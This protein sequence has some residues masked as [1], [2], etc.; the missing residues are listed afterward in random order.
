MRR[1][2]LAEVFR[3]DSTHGLSDIY[4]A[5][6]PTADINLDGF[7][8]QTDIPGLFL[9]SSGEADART[10]VELPFSSRIRELFARLH[11]EFDYV[12]IDTPPSIQFSDARILGQI[13]DGVILV[14]RSGVSSR[15]TVSL[16]VRRFEDDGVAIVGTILNHFQPGRNGFVYDDYFMKRYRAPYSGAPKA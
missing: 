12:L 5:E 3:L 15:G 14:I 6:T 11:K 9:M 8:K 13:S 10:V 4:T 1:P 2:R 16:T 7:I